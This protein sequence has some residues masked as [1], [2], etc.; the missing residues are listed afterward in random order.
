MI[1][2]VAI[3][4]KGMGGQR[5]VN[6]AQAKG[7]GLTR[8]G[9][10]ASCLFESVGQLVTERCPTRKVKSINSGCQFNQFS[11]RLPR[12]CP[13]VVRVRSLI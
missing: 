9:S 3:A 5:Q 11:V 4:K 12:R 6:I 8:G 2:T 1:E 13:H 10:V 7:N